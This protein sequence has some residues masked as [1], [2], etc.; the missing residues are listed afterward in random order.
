MNYREEVDSHLV[1]EWWRVQ[2]MV[3]MGFVMVK[4]MT[5]EVEK[6]Q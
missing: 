2:L 3:I 6:V 4:R 5:L 1:I